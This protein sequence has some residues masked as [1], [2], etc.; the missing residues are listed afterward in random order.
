MR[1][2][3]RELETVVGDVGV[4]PSSDDAPGER[5]GHSPESGSGTEGGH[6]LI[7]ASADVSK[8]DAREQDQGLTEEVERI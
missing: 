8:S 7:G 1:Q 2:G 6:D 3:E 4:T 5:T